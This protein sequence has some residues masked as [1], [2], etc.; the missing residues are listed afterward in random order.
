MSHGMERLLKSFSPTRKLRR[1]CTVPAAA[2]LFLCVCQTTALLAGVFGFLP[3]GGVTESE[4]VPSTGGAGVLALNKAVERELA[5]GGLDAHRIELASGQFLRATIEQWG[6]D[7]IVT[8]F[9][10]GGER[11]AEFYNR[12]RG[13]TPIS[14]IS[15]APGI[16]RFEVRPLESDAPPGRYKLAVEEMRQAKT[17]DESCVLAAR[18]FSEGERLRAQWKA[19]AMRE[20]IKRYEDALPLWRAVL[21]PRDEADTLNRI[22]DTYR[23]IGEPR[24]ALEYCEQALRL[25]KRGGDRPGEARS[26]NA[27]AYLLITIGEY[28]KAPGYAKRA[29]LLSR[30]LGDIRIE[31][32]ALSN[33]GDVYYANDPRQSLEYHQKALARWRDA[34]DR[35]GEAQALLSAGYT[36]FDL[37]EIRQALDSCKQALLLSRS[38]KDVRGEALTLTAL[39]H[40]YNRLGERQKALDL[41]GQAM[42]LLQPVEDHHGEAGIISG[43]AF[44]YR[45]M[46]QKER[47]LEFY[48]RA[49]GLYQ[50]T[51][52]RGGEA[53]MLI[54]SGRVY[55]A[56]G[57]DRKALDSYQKAVPIVRAL[58]DRRVESYALDGI[59]RIYDSM[60]D[61]A[62]ALESYKHAL[63]LRQPGVDSREE[64]YVLNN[65]G[66]L[67]YETGKRQEALDYYGRA[68]KLNRAA[69][70]LGGESLTLYNIARAERDRGNLAESRSRIEAAI[71]ISETLRVKVS[72]QELRYSYFAAAHEQYEFYIDLLMMMNK[73]RP[74]EGLDLL[75]LEASE[76]ARARSLLEILAETR[77][78]INQGV[79]PE[80]LERE[81]SLQQSLDVKAERRM[82]L[83]PGG[84]Q[85]ADEAATL[86]REISDLTTRYEEVRAQIRATSPHYA[87]LTQPQPL[88]LKE[89]QQQ[90]LDDKTL[91][92]EYTLGYERS[93]LWA[94]T[95]NSVTSYELPP[96]AEIEEAAR[97]VYD[98]L[99]AHQPVS[100]E[101]L[102]QR[103]A[104]IVAADE[105]YWQQAAALSRI[106]LGPVAGQ[107]ENKR[108]LIVADGALQYVPFGA[109]TPPR[110]AP[111][112]RD[113]Q[114]QTNSTDGPDELLPLM[115]D[116]EIVNLPSAST[117]AVLRKET[118][119]RAPAPMAVAVL[120]DPVFEKDDPR[121]PYAFRAHAS[122][123]PEQAKVTEQAGAVEEPQSAVGDIGAHV[124]AQSSIPRLLASRE[125]AEAIMQVTPTGAGLKAVGFD[126]SRATATSPE[127]SKYR[128][129]HFATHGR[130]NSAR[131]ELSGVLLSMVDQRGQPQNGFL[132][133]HDIYNLN[134][135]VDLVVLSAC[136]TGLGKDVK[137]EGLI[138]LTRG[139]MYAGASSVMASLWK[140]DDEAT[141][142]LMKRFYSGMLKDGLP[143]A[144]AL[145][146]A[147]M[148]MR[149]QKPWRSPYYW[150]AF[151]L[152]GEYRERI[153][154]KE[155]AQAGGRGLVVA[156][157]MAIV[158]S[159]GGGLYVRQRRRR[160]AMEPAVR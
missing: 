65:I 114:S 7:L 31:A 52:N 86:S 2:V 150:A 46:G 146:S 80:L 149:Q 13:T 4:P 11:L 88:S 134:L 152:Q 47:A 106:V 21:K 53:L 136:D 155:Q 105:Q 49:L 3:S 147:Q 154:I 145:R 69:K 40:F 95:E 109:L 81:R 66:S 132:R 140:V 27:L 73:E 17:G 56:L 117:L 82:R 58:A 32:Q 24:K 94:V 34:R 96:R 50:Q 41:Y 79:D 67:Y 87:A 83:Q 23:L 8:V 119:R 62:K 91:L 153:D 123:A 143:P 33:L 63:A 20:A 103:Q 6:I 122:A 159:I 9:G 51:G 77:A 10:P 18:L 157:A 158:F 99:L 43:I 38:V 139:F 120:A 61:K 126:A 124:D 42:Q 102:A 28:Q 160:N 137:G 55:S 138:G 78:D 19:E 15:E 70:D 72:N 25:S 98:L 26:L 35:R 127:L 125:E 30:A 5:G 130:I 14:I 121:I 22:G 48:Q 156:G 44:A 1:S 57:D 92:L 29:L 151:V 93:Y 60:G 104:R 97:R 59:G 54:Q 135:P 118:A 37:S 144:A 128:I 36:Y 76:R 75:A 148:R 142:E 112:G 68:L 12:E 89:I 84:S 16:Y 39:G 110:A 113:T 74:S 90:V 129:V 45:E 100:G 107:M 131:P 141:A 133:L 108:L 71:D 115:M 101:T 116:H 85:T 111:E 64:A